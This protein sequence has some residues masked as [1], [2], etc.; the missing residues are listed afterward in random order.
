MAGNVKEWCWNPTDAH[1][2]YILGGAW[3]DDIYMFTYPEARPPFDRSAVNGFRTVVYPNEDP[4]DFLSRP[5]ALPNR[6]YTAPDPVSDDV[7]RLYAQQYDYDPTP[8]DAVVELSDTESFEHWTKEKITFNAAYGNERL[9]AYLFLPKNVSPPYQTVIFFPGTGSIFES[10]SENL[11]PNFRGDFIL[12]SGRAFVVPIY[13]ST[14][15]RQDDLAETW[16]DA[17]RSFTDHVIMWVNDARRTIDYLMTREEIDASKLG[18][19]GFSW[20]GRMGP[21]V[22]AMEPRLS[23]G[24]LESGALSLRD[25]RP[26]AHQAHF[27]PRVTVPVLMLNGKWDFLEPMDTAQL[28]LFDLLGT[29]DDHKEHIVFDASHSPLPRNQVIQASLAWLDKYLGLAE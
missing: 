2:R 24:I 22:L 5:I 8:L 21:I 23:V 29:P 27:A 4:E 7:F 26:E 6:N 12:M 1:D 13:K 15:E 18:Y 17:T 16:P 14:Y 19:Y 10:S 11:G 3:I 25:A 9:A 20:G 28:P